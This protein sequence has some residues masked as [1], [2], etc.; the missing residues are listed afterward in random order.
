MPTN[1]AKVLGY[2]G[3]GRIGTTQVL[4]S[5]GGVN[6]E[7]SVPYMT[8][9]SVQPSTSSRSKVKQAD[10]TKVATAN[11]SFDVTEGLLNLLT[12]SYLLGRG[13]SFD[14]AVFDGETGQGLSD[15]YLTS[16]SLSGS[17]GGLINGSIQVTSPSAPIINTGSWAEFARDYGVYGYWYSGNTDVR[18]WTFSMSQDVQP[19]YTNVDSVWPTYLRVGLVDFSLE[20][21]TYDQL[22]EHDSISVVTKAFTLY[23]DTKS[24]GY[25]YGGQTELG[26]YTHTFETSAGMTSGA[27]D[28]ILVVS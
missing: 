20:V 27:G 2:A 22:H 13:Y 14:I 8:M 15:C 18:E 1:D 3:A 4:M 5:S 26:T 6:T 24:T 7:Y 12:T 19:V 25:T 9:L 28:T 16:L 11:M 23:G 21:T 10:G 17:P